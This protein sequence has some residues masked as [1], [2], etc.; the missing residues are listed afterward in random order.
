MRA[1]GV[2][3]LTRPPELP[4]QLGSQVGY[5]EGLNDA[6]TKLAGISAPCGVRLGGVL[7]AGGGRDRTDRGSDQGG[8]W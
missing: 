6:R 3:F 2:A 8:G 4:R 5:V 1:G 7:V